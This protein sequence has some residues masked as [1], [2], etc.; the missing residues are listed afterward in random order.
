[1]I[2]GLA[3]SKK[4]KTV[5]LQL[6]VTDQLSAIGDVKYTIDS[7][8]DWKGCLPEDSIY[9][10]MME[11]FSILIEELSIGQHVIAL[12]I[13]DAVKNTDYK[14]FDVTVGQD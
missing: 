6:Q 13:S 10:T 11:D 9:D 7:N 14:T 5:K 2:T 1:V 12:Q 8:A 4:K 3:I